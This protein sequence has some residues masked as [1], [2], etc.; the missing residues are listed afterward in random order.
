MKKLLITLV[1]LTCYF[2][3]PLNAM[4]NQV[5]RI[6]PTWQGIPRE[7]H[8][9]IFEFLT[10]KELVSKL[11]T[12]SHADLEQINT[13]F[14]RI[15][16]D[17]FFQNQ[18]YLF[19]PVINPGINGEIAPTYDTTPLTALCKVKKLNTIPHPTH[20]SINL[21]STNN[22]SFFGIYLLQL[23]LLD[24][25]NKVIK[26][27][28]TKLQETVTDLLECQ[29]R[30][31]TDSLLTKENRDTLQ[32]KLKT[33]IASTINL[34][35]TLVLELLKATHNN[36]NSFFIYYFNFITQSF[37]AAENAFYAGNYN[38]LTYII[39]ALPL[40]S[41]TYLRTMLFNKLH[42]WMDHN[43]IKLAITQR[44]FFDLHLGLLTLYNHPIFHD[45]VDQATRTNLINNCANLIINNHYVNHPLNSLN[46][47]NLLTKF[48]DQ[49]VMSP[50]IEAFIQHLQNAHFRMEHFGPDLA[51]DEELLEAID[52]LVN[53]AD[54]LNDASE[55]ETEEIEA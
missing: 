18:P 1:A 38:F 26:S 30:L 44:F 16:A 14:N 25:T 27:L 49:G 10:A 37:F 6:S 34:T 50:E 17:S 39:N 24:P 53:A 23:C 20:P 4:N 55:E 13:Y 51:L 41:N 52:K 36:H 42:E 7:M 47:I 33:L 29:T 19:H 35:K 21:T 54:E 8:Q 45:L 2:G 3:T 43:S 48:V 12:L 9:Y 40:T 32:S 22:S 28:F 5:A 31:E 46:G 11:A 15:Y